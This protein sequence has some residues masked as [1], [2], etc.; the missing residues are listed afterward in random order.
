MAAGEELASVRGES[1]SID[2]SVVAAERPR[3]RQALLD[4][5]H[6]L[7]RPASHLS[8]RVGIGG[9]AEGRQ[10]LDA[11]GVDGFGRGFPLVEVRAAEL[12]DAGLYLFAIWLALSESRW[13]TA[14]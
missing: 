9:L 7:A 6:E 11:Q 3:L 1:N 8:V 14:Y 12:G 13:P 4:A 10:G 2:A 5:V